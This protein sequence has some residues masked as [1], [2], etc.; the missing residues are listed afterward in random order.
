MVKRYIELRWFGVLVAALLVVL[1]YYTKKWAIDALSTQSI[2]V[3]DGLLNWHLAMNRGVSF[4]MLGDLSY[5]NLPEVLGVFALVVSVILIHW[6]GHHK[7]RLPF[8]LGLSFII[9]GAIGNGVDRF[10]Y[11]AVVDFIDVYYGMW[12]FPTFNVADICVNIGVILML[13][14]AYLETLG[15]NKDN[16]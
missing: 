12:H 14:D 7:G 10:A 8:V 9:A 16:V 15:D 1:D 2:S 3:V 11:G 4:S 6:M 13:V 5:K